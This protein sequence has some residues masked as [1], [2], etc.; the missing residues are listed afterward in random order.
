M[1]FKQSLMEN[2]SVLLNATA[3]DWRSAIIDS[4]C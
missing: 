2:D 4:A 3:S 1:K